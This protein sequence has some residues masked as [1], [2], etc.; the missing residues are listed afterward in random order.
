MCI[1][2]CIIYIKCKDV[3]K[4]TSCD[5]APCGPW[6]GFGGLIALVTEESGGSG[7]GL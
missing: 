3:I 2:Y 7:V 1:S 4:Q 5:M 6:F